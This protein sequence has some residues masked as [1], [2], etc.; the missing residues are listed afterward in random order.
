V[1]RTLGSLEAPD[2]KT[3]RA[4][5]AEEFHIPPARQSK[6]VVTKLDMRGLNKRAPLWRRGPL[7]CAAWDFEYGLGLPPSFRVSRANNLTSPSHRQCVPDIGVSGLGTR[8]S[9]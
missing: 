1:L 4:K 8:I 7:F 2:E 3:A 6:I 5:A 9:V